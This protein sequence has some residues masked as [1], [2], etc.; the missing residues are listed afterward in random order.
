VTYA[1]FHL[2]FLAPALL[3][4]GAAA[5]PALRGRGTAL[6]SCLLSMVAIAVLYTTPWDAFLIR[7]GIW[8]YGGDRV[9]ATW[10]GVPIE[11]Y[12]FFVLQTLLMGLAVYAVLHRS[13]AWERPFHLRP[14]GRYGDERDRHRWM[15]ALAWLGL[16]AG[17][18]LCLAVEPL[19]YMGLILAWAGPILALI[20]FVGGARLW[21][22]RRTLGP[23]IIVVTAYLW[24]A[25]RFAIEA[26][27]W[28]ISER[29]TI[30]WSPFGL[31]VEEAV[32]FLVTNL[33]VA[34]GLTMFTLTV[35]HRGG[36]LAKDSL[37]ERSAAVR[38]TPTPEFG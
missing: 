23:V 15:G 2:V 12:G 35:L 7:E 30:G 36:A 16:S 24:M 4:A 9:I 31:P 29:Y 5:L 17:G 10:L 3:L 22:L 18:A 26:G 19:R 6:V 27:I 38:D 8:W 13:G 1:R 25:D 14:F 32:F 21:A 20:W 33:M 11:E 37:P 28:T 34:M